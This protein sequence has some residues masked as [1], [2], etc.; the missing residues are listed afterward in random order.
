MDILLIIVFTILAYT[1]VLSRKTVLAFRKS[2]IKIS[3]LFGFLLTLYI[4]KV[5]LS[6]IWENKNN[7]KFVIFVFKQYF[8]RF[9]LPLTML[10]EV[11]T[12]NISTQEK[13][14][15]VSNSGSSMVHRWFKSRTA[16]NEYSDILED[17]CM[18]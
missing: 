2:R 13:T 8:L 7:F 1:A 9:D 11:A 17:Q 4:F 14:V 3:Y 15:S 18:A 16:R 6:I 10:V 12:E 5:H